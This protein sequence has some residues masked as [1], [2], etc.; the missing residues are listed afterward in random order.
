MLEVPYGT[1]VYEVRWHAIVPANDTGRLVSHGR[2]VLVLQACHPR[3]FATQRYLVYALP[4]Q[5]IPRLGRPYSIAY[6]R[7]AAPAKV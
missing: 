5:V 6:L 1:F 7:S 2:E 4:V 3:F